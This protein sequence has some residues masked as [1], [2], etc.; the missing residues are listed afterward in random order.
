[1]SVAFTANAQTNLNGDMNHDGE[2]NITDV[3]LL[4][5]E[6]L[7]GTKPQSYL[8]CPD[9]HHPHMIDLGLPSGTK[10]AC[11]NVDD[12]HSKQSPT[13]YGSYYAF[14]E[15]SEKSEYYWDTY[16]HCDDYL[17]NDIASTQYDV[18]HVQ[19]GGSWVMPSLEQA[20]ELINNCYSQWT[21]FNGIY[22]RSFTGNNGGIIF[23]PAAG[24][25]WYGSLYNDGSYGDYWSS[26]QHPSYSSYAFGLYCVSGSAYWDYSN[27]SSGHTVRPVSK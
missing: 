18:A 12:N 10:W 25:R 14:G 20:Q 24:Y 11:C 5:D 16:I 1:M 15:T 7:N 9:D 27:R 23:L 13:N 6:I 3:M 21:S 19:W 4:I 17:G 8:T 26:T 2:K 22:G